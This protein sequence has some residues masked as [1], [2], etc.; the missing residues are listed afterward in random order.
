M[1]GDAVAVSRVESK[2]SL[3]ECL[4]HC[5][6]EVALE[7]QGDLLSCRGCGA[8]YPIVDGVPV[9]T[10][11]KPPASGER[12]VSRWGLRARTAAGSV[13]WLGY[14]LG[15]S[16][17]ERRNFLAGGAPLA[18]EVARWA[19]Y[20]YYYS[21]PFVLYLKAIEIAL[22]AGLAVPRPSVEIGGAGGDVSRMAFEGT[23][24][25]IDCEYFVDNVFHFAQS[26]TDVY[27]VTDLH[28]GA[29]AFNLPLRS[30]AFGGL[31]L[32]HI[33]D[34]LVDIEAAFGEFSRILRGGGVL[35]FST[36]TASVHD[37]LP[38][39]RLCRIVSGRLAEAYRRWRCGR[40][41][42]WRG[43][44]SYVNPDPGNAAGMNLFSIDDWRR[45]GERHGL[46]LESA[47]PF[48]HGP[49][50]AA[51]MDL[52]HRS[53]PRFFGE[54]LRR[55][56]SHMVTKELREGVAYAERAAANLFLVFR[57][58]AEAHPERAAANARLRRGAR[59]RG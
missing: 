42:A 38:F 4:S 50:W 15:V 48:T 1:S 39:A 32:V 41:H 54:A 35:A 23:R 13:L 17:R 47:R 53:H 21:V 52:H 26:G 29:S 5:G 31:V 9:F 55:F 3:L 6:G 24:I 37:H 59:G 36:H 19:P 57:R 25:D 7:R 33:V 8:T 44:P 34:H 11:V 2:L 18:P 49:T 40:P 14:L 10:S 46:V 12:R 28:V 51:L 58:A 20:Y 43:A 16:L 22:F 30:A 56:V 45:L 27:A